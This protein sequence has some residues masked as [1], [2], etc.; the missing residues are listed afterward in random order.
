[1]KQ[2]DDTK[3]RELV[4]YIAR[5]SEDDPR[6]ASVKLNKILYYSDFEAYRRFGEPITG[7]VYKKLA[8]GPVP[9]DMPAQ[10]SVMLDSGD[11]KIEHRHYFNEVQQR[12]I[13]LRSPKTD[14]F[15][16]RELEVVD[17]IVEAMWRMT[18]RDATDLSRR[19]LGWLAANQGEVIPY[20][21]A[22][23]SPGPL[24]QDAEEHA[25]SLA[26]GLAGR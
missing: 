14:L 6:F 13:A 9:R 7:A 10:R 23:L 8:E 17:E 18:T 4:L 1:M 16:P 22:W 5:I 20:E 26:A 2:P 15:S 21:T 25:E 19:E 3:F 24:P 11:I 12:P